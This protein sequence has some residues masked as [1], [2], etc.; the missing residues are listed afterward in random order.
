MRLG[1]AFP[2]KP[3][4][5]FKL[6]KTHDRITLEEVRV[7]TYSGRI[8]RSPY[9]F[10]LPFIISF[11]LFYLYPVLYTIVMSFQE[12]IPGEVSFIGLENYKKLNNT[13]FFTALKNSSIYTVLTIAILIPVPM[14]LATLINSVS[15]AGSKILRSMLFI[16][17]LLS[18][19]VVG[20]L[21]RLIFGS[22]DVALA[23]KIVTA[24]G[25][26][27]QAWIISA[28]PQA[29]FLMVMIAIWRWTGIN[30]V[31]FMAGLQQIPTELYESA[32]IDGAHWWQSFF[33]ITV[34]L[35]KPT[36]I[37]VTAISIFGGLAMFEESYILWNAGSPD[38]A[39]LTIVRY[40][41]R[42]GF[43]AADMGFGSAVG[44]V[45]L[46]LVFL[47]SFVF[48]RLTGFFKQ[49]ST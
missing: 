26:E 19:V 6:Q 14:V 20:T 38:N 31:Y 48:L 44:I 3:F 39:G 10:I 47:V 18:V 11:G 29:M 22:S 32:Q 46:L 40:I 21:F 45:L 16:P 12:I 43:E 7:A 30:I 28:H 34:P 2:T 33:R 49:E 1:W 23:N 37:F 4:L 15:G 41:Y 17:A 27:A 25:G 5:S 35:L 24:L 13:Q 9:I 8:R 42:R 36:I